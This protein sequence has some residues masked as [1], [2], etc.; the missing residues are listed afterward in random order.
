VAAQTTPPS[1]RYVANGRVREKT[2]Y[3]HGWDIAFRAGQLAAVPEFWYSNRTGTV[4][5][6]SLGNRF[7]DPYSN[8]IGRLIEVTK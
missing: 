6:A 4:V 7:L 5:A 3:A 8:L 1:I 2:A